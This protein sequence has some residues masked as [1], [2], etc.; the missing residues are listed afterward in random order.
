M[1]TDENIARMK[2]QERRRQQQRPGDTFALSGSAKVALPGNA[3]VPS[4]Q[5]YDAGI[6]PVLAGGT[7]RA[8]RDI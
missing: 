5:T 7:P 4:A 6:L 2:E 1:A 3:D 8:P